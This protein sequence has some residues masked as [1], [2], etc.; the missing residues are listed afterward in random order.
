M[1][2]YLNLA[3]GKLAPI[4]YSVADSDFLIQLDQM[5]D[6]GST[7]QMLETEY[8][9][10]LRNKVAA[11]ED[12]SVDAFQFLSTFKYEFDVVSFYRF[13]EHISKPDIQGFIYLV[14]TAV[15]IGGIVDVIVP[16]FQIL[17]QILVGENLTDKV[18]HADWERH[19]TLVTYEMLN[20][21]SMPH[22]SIWT[23]DRLK[24][25]FELEE[26]FELELMEDEYNFDGRDIYTRAQF[27]RVK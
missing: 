4:D 11:T 5:Y 7:I 9:M 3:A 10:W 15:K 1:K 24:Y 13:L 23:P 21:P 22:A 12:T 8:E 17:A 26:R 19:D 20:E 25:F 18:R 6:G 14:S 16:N 27:K 2:S